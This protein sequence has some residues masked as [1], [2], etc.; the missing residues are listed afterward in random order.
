V[1]PA[2]RREDQSFWWKATG[3]LQK[4]KLLVWL[5][6]GVLVA[7]GFDFKTPAQ[8]IQS[9][10][11]DIKLVD[12]R[13]DVIEDKHEDIVAEMQKVTRLQ[14]FNEN[15]SR[16]ELQLVGIDCTFTDTTRTR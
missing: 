2:Q 6:V 15:Y 5:G 10:K 9:V 13:V 8:S 4:Y 3:T 7:F 12:A 11:D 14:C 1:N 16:R